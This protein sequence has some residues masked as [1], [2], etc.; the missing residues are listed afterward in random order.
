MFFARGRVLVPFCVFLSGRRYAARG[1]YEAALLI[2]IL[3]R[4]SCNV[5]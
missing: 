3:V 2:R 5:R 1:D 4:N